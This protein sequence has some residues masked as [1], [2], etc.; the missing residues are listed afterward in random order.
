MK[1]HK[2]VIYV[3]FS[4][5]W[6]LI[7]WSREGGLQHL[8]AVGIVGLH[9]GLRLQCLSSHGREALHS[10]GSTNRGNNRIHHHRDQQSERRQESFVAAQPN[11]F[12]RRAQ[13]VAV[14]CLPR[15]QVL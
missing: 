9:P 8:P 1:T 5:V 3:I 12:V 10:S 13:R 14:R 15:S 11:K 4:F 6:Y 2:R 7:S